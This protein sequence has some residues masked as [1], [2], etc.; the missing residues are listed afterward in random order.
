KSAAAERPCKHSLTENYSGRKRSGSSTN[1]TTGIIKT[2]PTVRSSL[3]YYI[4]KGWQSLTH[5][6]QEVFT[7]IAVP[8]TSLECKLCGNDIEP[9]ELGLGGKYCGACDNLMAKND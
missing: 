7:Q 9:F 5:R 8:A 1:L 3:N 4:D 6:Q 2:V